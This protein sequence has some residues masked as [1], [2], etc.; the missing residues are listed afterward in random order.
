MILKIQKS[1]L[2]SCEFNWR[3]RLYNEAISA[4]KRQRTKEKTWKTLLV[5][6][7][8]FIPPHTHT[9]CE[10]VEPVCP[11]CTW[12]V[13][14]LLLAE[15]LPRWHGTSCSLWWNREAT[16]STQLLSGCA[17]SPACLPQ[18]HHPSAPWVHATAI[19]HDTGS[20][21][22]SPRSGSADTGGQ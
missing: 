2:V 7:K 17:E 13:D 21:F 9:H 1:K 5:S 14:S 6:I 3:H 16:L 18:A 12:E 4:W 22:Q 20:P 11:P 8:H 19:T 15:A 10:V